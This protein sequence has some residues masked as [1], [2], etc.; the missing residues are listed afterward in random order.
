[1][2]SYTYST[3]DFPYDGSYTIENSTAGSGDIWWSTT[4]H[5]GNSG[6]YMMVVNASV[7]LTDY[8]YK[9]TITGLC[10]GTLYEFAAWVMNLLR[11][12]DLSPPNITFII[13]Q[14]DGTLINSYTT[15]SISL[16]SGPV[17]RQFGFYFT[18]PSNVS[19]VVVVMRNNSAGGAPAN[20]IALD[21]ITFR[22]CGPNVL[23]WIS[24]STGD[25]DTVC[26]HSNLTLHF[27]ST[28]S[29]GYSNPQYQWQVNLNGTWQDIPGA[30]SSDVLVFTEN[31]SAGTYK[32]RL[33]VGERVN[34]SSLQCRV[35][36]SELTLMVKPQPVATYNISTPVVC[37]NQPVQFINNTQSMNPVIYYWD[38]G[39]GNMSSEQNPSHLYS[40]SGIYNT[41]L[42]VTSGEGCADTAILTATID[43]RSVPSAAFTVTPTDT[44]IYHPTITF[45]DESV[46]AINCMIDWG[47]GIITV[48]SITR[49]VYTSPG[50]Y[51]I[52]EIVEN[53][54]GCQDTAY[55]T[56]IIR[57]EFEFR[58][59]NA[60]TPNGDGLNDVFKPNLLGVHDY[61]F[62][63]FNRW[64]Q[65]LF[66]THNSLEGWNGYFK[67]S[68]CPSAIYI[69]KI[70]FHDDVVNNFQVY[71]G[72]FTLL[73]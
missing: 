42:I 33:A 56:V 29:A 26:E 58:I 40:Q 15:G 25:T 39:D 70:T 57:S 10:P 37:A 38:F 28:V 63:V 73:Y 50:I 44:S 5:T 19:T 35:V 4:D 13:Q 59:P 41:S 61:I 23:T 22:P 3:N 65:I 47:D 45:I 36:S 53:A 62:L 67:G 1:M 69:Y 72:S 48:C 46:G 54:E 68:L 8:F 11:S 17:W 20:D 30:T 16:Q 31:Y 7:S 12:Q 55:S 51:V 71:S 60:F 49:H 64:G 9:K 66:E 18:T 34:F 14:T 6:G 32:F 2:T 43:L 24:E 21:D 27:K 52:T